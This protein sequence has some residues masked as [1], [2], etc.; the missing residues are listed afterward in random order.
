MLLPPLR[1]CPI[2][3]HCLL[4]LLR[5]GRRLLVRRDGCL[6]LPLRHCLL[7][8]LPL[9]RCLLLLLL[10]LYRRLQLLQ[11]LSGPLL[12]GCHVTLTGPESSG[13]LL[14]HPVLLLLLL[15]LL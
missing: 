12:K 1:C 5:Q 6:L 15:L 13:G 10:H 4:L 8:L 7:L 14:Q 9:R 3:Y 11:R 2:L